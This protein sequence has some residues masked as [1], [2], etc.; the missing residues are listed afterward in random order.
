MDRGRPLGRPGSS[1]T[2]GAIPATGPTWNRVYPF[3]SGVAE[4]YGDYLVRDGNGIYQILPSQSP[5][6]F[7]TDLEFPVLLGQSSAMDVQ[8][9]Y[10][11]LTYAIEAAEILGKDA[12]LP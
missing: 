7:I 8:L 5:E 9:C 4:F 11:A 1:G 12:P 2:T 3:F 6:N 10:D